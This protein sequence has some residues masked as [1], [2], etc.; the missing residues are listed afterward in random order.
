[1]FV[2]K[3]S[4]VAWE[5]AQGTPRVCSGVLGLGLFFIGDRD[6]DERTRNFVREVFRSPGE[7]GGCRGHGEEPECRRSSS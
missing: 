1:M 3:G 2:V 6:G 7:L 5:A 4:S